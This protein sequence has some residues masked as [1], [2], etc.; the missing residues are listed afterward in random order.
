MKK[1]TVLLMICSL[2]V[3][4]TMVFADNDNTDGVN[5]ATWTSTGSDYVN[6]DSI[7]RGNYFADGDQVDGQEA[8]VKMKAKAYIPCYLKLEFTGN[9]GKTLIE[10]F[11]P[12]AQGEVAPTSY[13]IVFD[14][15]LGG[16]VDSTWSVLGT[17]SNAEIAPGADTYIAACDTFKVVVYSNDNFK[18]DVISAPLTGSNGDLNLIMGTSNIPNGTYSNDIFDAAKTILIA[19]GAPCTEITRYHKFAVPYTTSTAQGA[20]SGDITFKAYT[21]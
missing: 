8:L 12:N 19:T 2:F 13:E 6:D 5:T 18:Y 14:N 3:I 7:H 11:G 21:I 10:S 16:F 9:Q 1:L 4:A 20:Y 17:G 15:E